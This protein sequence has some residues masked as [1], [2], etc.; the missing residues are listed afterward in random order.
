MG[1]FDESYSSMDLSKILGVHR[2]T[3]AKWIKAGA[4]KAIQTPGGRYKVSKDSLKAFLSERGMDLP[5]GL[6][7][8]DKKLVV[9]VDDDLSILQLFERIFSKGEMAFFY[10]LKTFLDPVEAALFIGDTKPDLVL[11]DLLMPQMNGF[12]LTRQLRNTCPETR[13]IVVTGHASE[14]NR[15]RLKAHGVDTVIAKPFTP[16]QLKHAVKNEL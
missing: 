3:V 10:E 1:I 9:A 15:S 7:L 2:V 6:R 11:L 8:K 16:D 12:N 13:I 4:L 14:E 5:V